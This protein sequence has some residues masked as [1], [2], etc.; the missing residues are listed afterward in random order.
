M[1]A[2]YRP[3]FCRLI[4]HIDFRLV[5]TSHVVEPSYPY[6]FEHIVAFDEAADESA[7][8]AHKNEIVCLSLQTSRKFQ[9]AYQFLAAAGKVNDHILELTS[10]YTDFAKLERSAYRLAKR[11]VPKQGKGQGVKKTRFLSGITPDGLI[12]YFDSARSL[13]PDIYV[14][15]DE[16]GLGAY[17]LA[18]IEEYALAHGC[19]VISCPCPMAPK[20]RLEHLL[21]PE[22]GIGFVTSKA[23][24]RDEGDYARRI[25]FRR[26][27]DTAAL[28]AHK[29]SLSFSKRVKKELLA[30]AVRHIEDARMLH[31]KLEGCYVPFMNFARLDTLCKQYINQI[32]DKNKAQHV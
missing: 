12:T 17:F 9:K 18:V 7:I 13:C 30:E 3:A 24:H 31:T 14:L 27:I 11:I 10:R 5:A 8:A 4:F 15:E 26:F 19:D 25:H 1:T 32:I 21:I 20:E 23:A 29:A 2:Q 28:K 16:Y 22:I 6:A